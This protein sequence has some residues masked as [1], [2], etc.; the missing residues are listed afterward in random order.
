MSVYHGTVPFGEELERI[1]LPEGS[2]AVDRFVAA[3]W[4]RLGIRPSAEVD[5]ATWIRRVSLDIC[6]TLPTVE[7]VELFDTDKRPGRRDR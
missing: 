5:D 3:G 4:S 6:G 7:E 2:S 1:E